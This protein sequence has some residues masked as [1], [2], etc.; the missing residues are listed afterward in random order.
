MDPFT[1][2]IVIKLGLVVRGFLA[3]GV[4][5]ALLYGAA[6]YGKPQHALTLSTIPPPLS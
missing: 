2:T 6:Q 3:V 1:K 4:I 5:V